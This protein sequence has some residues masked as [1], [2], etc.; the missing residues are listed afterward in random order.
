M[1]SYDETETPTGLSPSADSPEQKGR[2]LL[3]GRGLLVF[4]CGVALCAFALYI[5][6]ALY[7]IFTSH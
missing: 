2:K 5:F 7:G 3:A 6:V 4:I 1:K